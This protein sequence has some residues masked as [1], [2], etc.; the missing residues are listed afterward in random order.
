MKTDST[1][2]F[3]QIA[4][5][6]DPQLIPTINDLIEKSK[7]PDKLHIVVNWQH[8]QE[9]SIED[10]LQ[11]NFS[12][13]GV[14]QSNPIVN[15][16]D[17][18]ILTK[19][20][21]TIVLIEVSFEQSKGA[22]WARNLIQQLYNG[23]TYTLQLDSH[24]RFI[25]DWDQTLIE[26][27]EGLRHKSSKPLLTAYLPSFD[28]E[29]DPIG[30][31][32]IP[33]KMNFDRF[34][35]E[36]AVF[37]MPASI[38]EWRDLKEP[39]LSRFYSGH[40]AFADG[41]FA[42]EVQHDP[43]YFFHGEEISIAARAFT[44]GY[45]LYHPHILIC[46]H[47]YTRK[48]RTKIWDDHTQKFKEKGKT[49]LN[50]VERNDRCHKRNRIL[51]GMDGEDQNQIDFGKY[52]FGS[53]RTL[54]DYERYAGLSFK[55]RAVHKDA[56]AKINPV[57]PIPDKSDEQW[58]SE[59]C[60]SRDIHIYVHRNDLKYTNELGEKS[61]LD[62][63][64]CWMVAAYDMNGKEIHRKDL[65]PH[66]IEKYISGTTELIDF[67]LIFLSNDYPASYVIQPHSRSKGWLEKVA[68]PCNEHINIIKSS[69]PVRK[70][71]V[72]IDIDLDK[73]KYNRTELLSDYDCIIIAVNDATGKEIYRRDII[74][75]DIKTFINLDDN[76][77]KVNL[78][79]LA[80]SKPNSFIVWPHSISR[81][82]LD[83]IEELI[84]D[85]SG[86]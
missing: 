18:I 61:Y 65:L 76:R 72:K 40:F 55:K 26:M 22:C 36:G 35:P 47:E 34:I 44:H 12:V 73:I 56:L 30:R 32:T 77:F 5:Y 45:D 67:R 4:S 23:E 27:L 42:I 8:G 54:K 71:Q 84:H 11:N 38:D 51:F 75:K 53:V 21:A 80:K 85:D 59:I 62:D 86:N 17:T 3:V 49:D 69:Q 74:R 52:G 7:N 66:E 63:Y 20:Y 14:I 48:G 31:V 64:T 19:S 43:N 15:G 78:N 2:I 57:L 41:S 16:F 81:E 79:F 82:W 10:F 68:R 39:I 60:G 24:H 9:E 70:Y 58:E 50:W 29:N 46:W 83:R 6:R 13:D 37:F 33:W 28:P 25:Q 1:T